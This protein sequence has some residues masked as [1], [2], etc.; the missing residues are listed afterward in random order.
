[1]AHAVFASLEHV[2]TD[3]LLA[4]LKDLMGRSN[5]LTAVMLVHLAEVDS[6]EAY[7]EHACSSLYAYCVYELR[8]SEDEAQRRI[9][10]ARAGRR[11]TRAGQGDVIGTGRQFTRAG[12]GDVTR[13]SAS[14]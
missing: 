7:R 6:R 3:A 12:Q 5:Q 9:V 10:A 11:F 13:V 1:M 8:M 14:S 2:P 4:N